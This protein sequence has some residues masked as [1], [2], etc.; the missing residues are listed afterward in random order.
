VRAF[1]FFLLFNG[2][3]FTAAAGGIA[4][5]FGSPSI[6]STVTPLTCGLG[7]ATTC[8]CCCVVAS[9]VWLGASGAEA[10]SVSPPALSHAAQPPTRARALKPL[11]L[12]IRAA[13]ALVAS[14]GQAQ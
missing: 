6:F 4:F 9:V 7:E 13:R 1:L 3:A 12:S 5:A 2:L 14:L 10:G 11:E 8:F